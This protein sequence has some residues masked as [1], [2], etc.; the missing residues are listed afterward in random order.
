MLVIKLWLYPIAIAE[1]L[2]EEEEIVV[3]VDVTVEEE[4]GEK[5]DTLEQ[6]RVALLGT[7]VVTDNSSAHLKVKGTKTQETENIKLLYD[8][9]ISNYSILLSLKKFK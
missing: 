7:I 2:D 3:E 5:V 4:A 9:Y 8:V 1:S 6:P